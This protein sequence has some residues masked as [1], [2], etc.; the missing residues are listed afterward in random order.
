MRI[1]FVNHACYLLEH[2][3]VKLLHDPWLSG[4]AFHN[5]WALIAPSA[6]SYERFAEVTHI[7]FSHEH[8]DHFSPQ[9]LKAIAPEHRAG[10]TVLFHK[11][12]DRKVVDYC[13]KLGFGEVIEL[14]DG[15]FDLCPEFSVMNRPHTDGD[16][17]LCAR[18]NGHYV[19]NINDC[20]LESDAALRAILKVIGGH[21]EVLLTQF[22]YA[23][24][25]GNR[26]DTDIRRELAASKLAEVSRQIR[27]LMPKWVVPFASFIWFCHEENFYR[28]DA[29]NP[30]G[31][32]AQAITEAGARPLVMFNGDTWSLGEDH[33]SE[34][35]VL[36][37]EKAFSEHV[38][39]E[40]VLKAAK[41]EV[42]ELL[43]AGQHFCDTL[44]NQNASWI[45]KV[46]KPTTIF[47]TDL[48]LVFSLA[49][50]HFRLAPEMKPEFC[51][52][53]L[54]SEAML[55]CFKHLWGGSTLRI[56]GRYEAPLKGRF[57]R[58][59]RYFNIA[60]LNNED[61]SVN[62]GFALQYLFRV[63]QERLRA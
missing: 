33:D 38:R 43:N 11:T 58:F 16:S 18:V 27:V 50:W 60:Q 8:P 29:V 45:H 3:D 56:N 19:L 51:D 35:A 57:N 31:L 40:L 10:I 5:G 4:S 2:G 54:G 44:R 23:N 13:R 61:Y 30:V 49:P 22:S 28:N 42:D 59:K 53:H 1:I 25:A 26:N 46:L 6:W 41:I 36:A 9:D 21:P 12:R 20:N 24:A 55:Y 63:I 15:W 32:A 14:G 47:I 39:P 48:N 37:W 62:L 52:V 34:S 7:W 17:W